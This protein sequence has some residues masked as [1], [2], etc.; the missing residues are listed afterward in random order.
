M[1]SWH[2]KPAGELPRLPS[3]GSESCDRDLESVEAGH[4]AV[5]PGTGGADASSDSG[6]LARDAPRSDRD[7]APAAPHIAMHPVTGRFADPAHESIF[8][9]QLFRLAYP[10]HF[11]LIVIML[12]ATVLIVLGATTPDLKRTWLIGAI[13]TQLFLAG[14]VVLHR[15][16][17]SERGQRLGSRAWSVLYLL[18]A[19]ANLAGYALPGACAST[20]KLYLIPVF[21][22]VIALANGTLG[23]GFAHKTA[24]IGVVVAAGPI[25]IG[26]C[27]EAAHAVAL[28]NMGATLIGAVASHMVLRV[29]VQG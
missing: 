23:M 19:L 9:A 10:G 21:G 14:R 17:D 20:E 15:H 4:A 7:P 13:C 5:A 1:F 18:G 6:L 25:I 11:L 16:F 28:C 12:V 29:R 26:I 27:G 3:G 22:L 8:A 2:M 24:L